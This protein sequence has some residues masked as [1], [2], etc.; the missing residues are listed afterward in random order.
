MQE[1]CSLPRLQPLAISLLALALS[2]HCGPRPQAVEER[3]ALPQDVCGLLRLS[4][5]G[6]SAPAS[7]EPLV[8]RTVYTPGPLYQGMRDNDL[9]G[10]L[11]GRF[12]HGWNQSTQAHVRIGRWPD[13][14]KLGEREIFRALEHWSALGLP[15]TA[16]VRSASLHLAIERGPHRDVPVM[17]YEVRKDW[18]AGE[19]GILHDSTSPPAR[20][21]VWWD[22]VA[23]DE[24]SWALP[25]ASLAS[26]T[27][28]EADTAAMPLAEAVYHAGAAQLSFE[29]DE[30][31][32]YVERR[33][34]K[35]RPLLLLLKVADRYEDGLASPLF[36]F[37]SNVDG[38][39]NGTRRPHLELE[40]DSP[41]ET[42][43]LERHI[44]LEHGRQ[45]VLEGE[46]A[47]R[48]AAS[49]LADPG[50]E[51]PTLEVR[52]SGESAWR[53]A[54]LPVRVDGPGFE[55]RL[56]AAHDPLPYGET[57]R[58]G[59]RDTWV[60]SGPPEGQQVVWTFVSPT[61]IVSRA[62][63]DY[64]GSYTWQVEF[65][66]AELGRWRYWFEHRLH[67][68]FRSSEGRFDVVA[69]DRA[70]VERALRDLL[71][72]IR[73]E[74][75]RVAREDRRRLVE[76]YGPTFWRLERAAMAQETPETF[77]ARSGDP[78][79]A[80]ITEIREAMT[81]SPVPEHIEPRAYERG[82]RQEQTAERGTGSRRQGAGASR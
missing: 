7:G 23:H 34:R 12:E 5:F 15:R 2:T 37:S 27:L 69:G 36:L 46:G 64:L 39:R 8:H 45:V 20:G 60:T 73:T 55:L 77:R 63:G 26:D 50:C 21:E 31:R 42:S 25:G 38:L 6:S 81:G 68:G 1:R 53:P 33:V 80:L 4:T 74:H 40:W 35:G 30:L 3:A 76:E 44:R 61:G 62:D 59:F 11:D 48:L 51:A 10:F 70:H 67:R 75:P 65:Q 32:A 28:P 49:F 13:G 43:R 29:S 18:N 24:Q 47:G 71:A 16:R 41:A 72:R 19:G 66:P 54:S 58:S 52:S 78:L 57:F 79:L 17:L 22:E 82:Y 14:E 56:V 9:R